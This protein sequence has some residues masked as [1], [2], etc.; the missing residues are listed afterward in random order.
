MGLTNSKCSLW[1]TSVSTPKHWQERQ[2]MENARRKVDRRMWHQQQAS[3]RCGMAG[4]FC[5]GRSFWWLSHKSRPRMMLCLS[6]PC[7]NVGSQHDGPATPPTALSADS[8]LSSMTALRELRRTAWLRQLWEI[9]SQPNHTPVAILLCLP[10]TSPA[11]PQCKALL[12]SIPSWQILVA[13]FSCL[14]G[15]SSRQE[16]RLWSC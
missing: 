2:Q 12:A 16:D 7:L 5:H 11:L 13:C 6:L 4:T 10:D 3:I 14:L 15:S 9:M 8:L 1:F